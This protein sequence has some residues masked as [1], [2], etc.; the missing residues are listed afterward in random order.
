MEREVMGVVAEEGEAAEVL[1]ITFQ[2]QGV[3]EILA[4]LEE[5]AEAV[6]VLQVLVVLMEDQIVVVMV[7]QEVMAEVEGV[8]ATAEE[9]EV[10]VAA[11][12]AALD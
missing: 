5:G 7:E 2:E 6:E 1:L 8:A 4:V 9:V 12:L 3:Q 11:A 10:M